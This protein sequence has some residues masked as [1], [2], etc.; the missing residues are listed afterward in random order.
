MLGPAG[1]RSVWPLDGA[2]LT[3]QAHETRRAHSAPRGASHT[4]PKRRSVLA[5]RVS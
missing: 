4:L 3:G 5:A 1:R 2:P